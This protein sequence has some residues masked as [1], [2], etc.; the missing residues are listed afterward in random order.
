M[1]LTPRPH[2]QRGRYEIPVPNS[3]HKPP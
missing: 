3:R 2:L 1:K